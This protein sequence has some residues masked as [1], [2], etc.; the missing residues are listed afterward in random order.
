MS[1]QSNSNNNDNNDL[2]G[3][4]KDQ[5]QSEQQNDKSNINSEH[6]Y[7]PYQPQS[8]NEHAYNQQQQ[9]FNPYEANQQQQPFNQPGYQQQQQQQQSFNQPMY[10][11]QNPQQPYGNQGGYYNQPPQ[12]GT[13]NFHQPGMPPQGPYN[14]AR[15]NT[16]SIVALV[17][18]IAAICVP[19][20]GFLIGIAGIIISALSLKEIPKRQE[21]GKG[22][23]IAGLVTSIIGVL[24]Y[25]VIFLF[26]IIALATFSDVSSNFY[27]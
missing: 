11:Q 9:S 3:S 18:G 14:N 8:S 5:N 19:Y 15:T 23:A 6:A 13:P 26:I 21:N 20:L 27:Y 24:I 16:K 1:D 12:Y 17:L 2:Y 10:N 22:L 4:Y 25:A 7:E